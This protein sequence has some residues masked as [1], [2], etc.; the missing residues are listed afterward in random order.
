MKAVIF[1]CDAHLISLVSSKV[2]N[3]NGKCLAVTQTDL[4]RTEY[5]PNLESISSTLIFQESNSAIVIKH[6]PQPQNFFFLS[7]Y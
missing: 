1:A 3:K 7:N 6:L 4:E 5:I 2:H